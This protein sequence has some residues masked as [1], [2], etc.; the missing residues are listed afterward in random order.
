MKVSK[1]QCPNHYITITLIFAPSIFAL[2]I[3]SRVWFGIKFR[4]LNQNYIKIINE[5]CNFAI[6]K[7][8]QLW[9]KKF[10]TQILESL[11]NF[12]SI[13]VL[14][15]QDMIGPQK[16]LDDQFLPSNFFCVW[17]L[18]CKNYLWVVLPSIYILG[19]FGIWILQWKSF[20][21]QTYCFRPFFCFMI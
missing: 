11:Y 14:Y 19:L 2:P 13:L 18:S 7:I 4:I 21:L 16:S 9:P 6:L 1:V 15:R 12:I 17:K 3:K 5:F 8:W 20:V 10:I